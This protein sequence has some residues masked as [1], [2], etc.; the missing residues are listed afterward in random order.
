MSQGKVKATPQDLYQATAEEENLQE[1]NNVSLYELKFPEVQD[2]LERNLEGSFHTFALGVP[3]EKFAGDTVGLKLVWIEK[4]QLHAFVDDTDKSER[5]GKDG[6]LYYSHFIYLV[7]LL[8]L[9]LF[10]VDETELKPIADFGED[11]Q[12][13]TCSVLRL[14]PQV[15][16]SNRV[17]GGGSKKLTFLIGNLMTML[18]TKRHG[19]RQT[20]AVA[21]RNHLSAIL[22]D[23]IYDS[24]NRKLH[25][26]DP[27]GPR[28]MDDLSI[29]Q[30]T[31]LSRHDFF[32]I[33]YAKLDPT[34]YIPRYHESKRKKEEDQTVPTEPVDLHL[35]REIRKE[36]I[37]WLL[38]DP[39]FVESTIANLREHLAK[40]KEPKAPSGKPTVEKVK[41]PVGGD[42][43]L[44]N[45]KGEEEEVPPPAPKIPRIE[46]D[47]PP[48]PPAEVPP[49][50]PVEAAPVVETV[51]KTRGNSRKQK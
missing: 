12:P 25:A 33:K 37:T 34:G 17:E 50:A 15:K 8:I 28:Y 6:R 3:L 43:G 38:N 48:L 49:P 23:E 7:H 16:I 1:I 27:D 36:V 44:Y 21:P 29:E 42:F 4:E 11:Y 13:R 26:N 9:R 14:V 47:A 10:L 20:R 22:F 31:K 41:R 5:E 39:N 30:I 32:K 45:S 2:F 46:L 35:V 19:Q 51:H 40:E 24:Y 18:P